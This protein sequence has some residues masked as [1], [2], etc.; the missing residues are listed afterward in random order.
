MDTGYYIYRHVILRFHPASQGKKNND[1]FGSSKKLEEFV[2]CL[3]A[4]GVGKKTG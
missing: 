4:G 3:Y 2:P 1:E